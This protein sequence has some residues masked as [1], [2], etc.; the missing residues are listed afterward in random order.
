MRIIFAPEFLA[1]NENVVFAMYSAGQL[2]PLCIK[3][4]TL[5]APGQFLYRQIQPT[6]PLNRQDGN[7]MQQL[8]GVP[9]VE[10]VELEFRVQEMEEEVMDRQRFVVWHRDDV[11]NLIQALMPC[12]DTVL[13]DRSKEP[14][15]LASYPG[16]V[17]GTLGQTVRLFYPREERT[18]TVSDMASILHS[19]RLYPELRLGHWDDYNKPA[20]DALLPLHRLKNPNVR[21]KALVADIELLDT[22]VGRQILNSGGIEFYPK[23]GSMCGDVFLAGLY[24]REKQDNLIPIHQTESSVN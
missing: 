18:L 4:Q 5:P 10:E 3:G 16:V 13:P 11:D 24:V 2:G 20:K 23:Y 22:P 15:V 6:L 14:A 12:M 21:N 17:L 19:L 8:L 1:I 9:P 7:A